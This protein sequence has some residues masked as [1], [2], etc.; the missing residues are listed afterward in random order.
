[1][2]SLEICLFLILIF[3]SPSSSETSKLIVFAGIPNSL[4]GWKTSEI[5][6]D[7]CLGQCWYDPD[8]R[9]I[10]QN[11][12]SCYIFKRGNI[13]IQTSTDS[14]NRVAVKIPNAPTDCL[15]EPSDLFTQPLTETRNESQIIRSEFSY[16]NGQYRV[17]YTVS[18]CPLNTTLYTRTVG[19]TTYHVCVGFRMFPA[20]S[21]TFY[22][23]QKLC[24]SSGG[25]G[26]SGP[27]DDKEHAIFK[28]QHAKA[29]LHGQKTVFPDQ[30]I[31]L[32]KQNGQNENAYFWIDGISYT[33]DPY[34]FDYEDESHNGVP[35]NLI[36]N[37]DPN[38]TPPSAFYMYGAMNSYSIAD[39]GANQ[40][41][42]YG[43]PFI[44]ALCRVND[45]LQ[46]L[47][48]S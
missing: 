38:D 5:S 42:F 4:D 9:V 31:A 28:G 10:F 34:T 48:R 41:G 45:V 6:W 22:D 39:Y 25:Y 37:G 43:Y 26:L 40:S 14:K 29:E 21:G 33:K 8:C 46:D 7:A 2:T 35:T 3:S 32:R 47:P 24:N 11:T 15:S 30:S 12:S 18:E 44:G 23:A 27:W 13:T 17:V 36:H 19:T 1:M 20:G 16:S